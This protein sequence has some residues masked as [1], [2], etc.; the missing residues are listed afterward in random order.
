MV[1]SKILRILLVFIIILCLILLP[2]FVI[3]N[4]SYKIYSKYSVKTSTRD[5]SDQLILNNIKNKDITE[6]K[7]IHCSIAG[8]YDSRQFLD[9]LLDKY[10]EGVKDYDW[11]NA[12]IRNRT[13]NNG[14]IVDNVRDKNGII[15]SERFETSSAGFSYF[16]NNISVAYFCFWPDYPG[17][18]FEQN[19]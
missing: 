12:V 10:W 9:N 17:N 14:F 13:D 1:K 15:R 4:Y 2:Y 16:F 18:Y 8:N 5:L 7:Y 3:H 6:L 11:S 19:K